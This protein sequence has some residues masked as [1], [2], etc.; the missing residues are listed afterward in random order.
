[1]KYELGGQPGQRLRPPTDYPGRAAAPLG[2]TVSLEAA[3]PLE[4]AAS[5][6]PAGSAAPVEA[7]E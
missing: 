7:A 3:A 5:P 1:L 6:G 2:A 4:T